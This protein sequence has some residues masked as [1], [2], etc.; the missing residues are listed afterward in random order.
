[1]VYFA[2]RVDAY[3]SQDIVEVCVGV[4]ARQRQN[5]FA[6]CKASNKLVNKSIFAEWL[7]RI[8]LPQ[9]SS[10]SKAADSTAGTV[11]S[12]KSDGGVSCPESPQTSFF[13]QL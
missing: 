12:R 10:T 6:S 1:V 13:R 4:N 5:R 7:T 3:F 8:T 11:T 9:G 2:C